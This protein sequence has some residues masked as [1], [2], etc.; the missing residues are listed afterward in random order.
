MPLS[1]EQIARNMRD[2]EYAIA[3][4]RI[5]GLTV[6][7]EAQ[8]DMRRVARGE[9]T[10]AEGIERTKKRIA[11]MVQESQGRDSDGSDGK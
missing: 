10:V 9:M 3:Q 5:E 6:S 4:Q 1:E 8:A 11:R 2:V 7:E